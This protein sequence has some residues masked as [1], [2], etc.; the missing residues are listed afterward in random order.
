MSW[1]G[2]RRFLYLFGVALFFLVVVGIPLAVYLYRPAT[3]TDGI[4]NQEET[5]PDRGGPCPLLDESA[6]SPHSILWSRAFP[7]RDGSYNAVAYIENP[8]DRA[9]VLSVPYRFGLYDENNILVAERTGE[10]YIMPLSITPVFAGTISTGNRVVARTYFEFTGPMTWQKL[11][12]AT[13]AI[14]IH[15]KTIGDTTTVPR[16]AASVTNVSVA[17]VKDVTLTAVVFDPAGNAFAASQT[18][19][20]RLAPQETAEIVFTW[21][22][23]FPY[24][25]GR[26]DILAVMPPVPETR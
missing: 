21:P 20:T 18:T 3:C 7:V 11:T 9:G 17:T 2:R 10:M 26:L 25:V 8:N 5:S 24:P 16:A 23:P 15:N 19:L 12:N 4:Q 1:A 13:P 6:L 14:S 22:D